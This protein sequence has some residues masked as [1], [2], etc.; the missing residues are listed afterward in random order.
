MRARSSLFSSISKFCTGEGSVFASLSGD[1]R[2]LSQYS[3][4]ISPS[5]SVDSKD[6]ASSGLKPRELPLLYKPR[7]V[8]GGTSA[9][10]FV[11]GTQSSPAAHAYRNPLFRVLPG[12]RIVPMALTKWIK[13]KKGPFRPKQRMYSMGMNVMPLLGAESLPS[14]AQ[15]SEW[16]P[17]EPSIS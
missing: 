5:A 13:R 15:A 1:S 12:G 7:D 10:P 4:S 17:S 8:Y 11:A 14:S 3:T 2:V 16:L 6:Q 9:V